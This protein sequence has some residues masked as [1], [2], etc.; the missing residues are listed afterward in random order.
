MGD[1]VAV[2]R[3]GELQQVDSPQQAL[4][5]PGQP[6]RRE[7]H[8]QPR[9][10]PGR[11]AARAPRRRSRLRL[12]AVRTL[13]LP[14]ELV[15]RAPGT[16]GVRGKTIGLGIRPEQLEDAA[17][18]AP[19]PAHGRLRGRVVTDR[20]AR[21]GAARPRRDRGGAGGHAGGRG[22]VARGR[23]PL[24]GG[25]AGERGA[26]TSHGRHRPL[27]D[28]LACPRRRRRS[29]CGS[30]PA[31][32]TSSTST[33]RPRSGSREPSGGGRGTRDGCDTGGMMDEGVVDRLQVARACPC[34]RPGSTSACSAT[35]RRTATRCRSPPGSHPR[36]STP[37]FSGSRP[38]ASC[39]R[40]E[41][42]PGRSTSASPRTNSSTASGTSSTS[43]LHTSRE[44]SPSWPCS[45]RQ[46]R[47][48][49]SPASMR[50]ERTLASSSTP[51]AKR[52]TSPYGPTTS[53]TCT[54]ARRRPRAECPDLRD[55]LRRG[56]RWPSAPG[57]STATSRSSP[58]GSAAAC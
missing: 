52:S 42:A 8:R 41:P 49:R 36:R 32:C 19:V 21:L 7:L 35:G 11:G 5:P 30:I 18:A 20:T 22:E 10:E 54:T 2:L 13:A 9:D 44:H 26:R 14:P 56:E 15:A 53:S 1:R 57:S 28:R 23:R 51:R 46:P 58:T 3:K 40:C 12:S 27:R 33:P 29:R 17:V 50:S 34:T 37:A 16:R 39:I 25:R 4:R 38:G 45:S 47:C 6:V 24:A 55:A 43:R 31:G 48:S